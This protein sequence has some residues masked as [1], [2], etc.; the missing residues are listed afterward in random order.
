MK[1]SSPLAR[2]RVVLYAVVLGAGFLA[3]WQSASYTGPRT[4]WVWLGVWQSTL[5]MT[6]TVGIELVTWLA[7]VLSGL[8]A[9]MRWWGVAHAGRRWQASGS[10]LLAL[11]VSVLMPP[12]GALVTMPA[13]VVYEVVVMS[14]ADGGVE[15]AK[16]PR[17]GRAILREVASLGVF[18]SFAA[19]SWQY[20]ARLLEQ[21]LLI[22]CG[23]GLIARAA[24]PTE[25]S[26]T[27]AKKSAA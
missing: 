1:Q 13:I 7:V 17:W 9:L 16:T 5:G 14:G 12:V 26:A 10:L 11:A 18:V 21:A 15:A 3:P 22:T 23:L 20:N 6:S 19:L 4:L 8:G 24:L 2:L 27:D 25:A